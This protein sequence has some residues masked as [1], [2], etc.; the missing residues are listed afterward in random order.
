M[1][2]GPLREKPPLTRSTMPDNG[3]SLTAPPGQFSDRQLLLS[4]AVYGL[5]MLAP[6]GVD[7]ELWWRPGGWMVFL[8]GAIFWW[9][10]P[11][12]L[13]KAW[14]Q[15]PVNE[16]DIMPMLFV[17]TWLAN[18]LLYCGWGTLASGVPGGAGRRRL[19]AGLFLAALLVAASGLP[20]PPP[21]TRPLPW[22]S[23]AYF[24]WRAGM[25]AALVAALTSPEAESAPD[26]RPA[27]EAAEPSHPHQHAAEE[28]SQGITP[29]SPV[30]S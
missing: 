28:H 9:T 8:W 18:V 17:L 21:Y 12:G 23:P 13:V 10:A 3:R 5:S 16:S 4:L 6:L 14:T 29:P 27:L 24:V 7:S 15:D 1:H 26:L 20:L 30:E 25:A 19:A 2:A 11:V 22:A